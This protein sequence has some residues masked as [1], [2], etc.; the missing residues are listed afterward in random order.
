MGHWS[1]RSARARIGGAAVA[2]WLLASAGISDAPLLP[3]PNPDRAPQASVRSFTRDPDV[4]RDRLCREAANPDA[5]S[6]KVGI[7]CDIEVGRFAPPSREGPRHLTI[8]AFN[9]ARGVAAE[10]QILAFR[11]GTLPRPDVMLVSEAD[12]GCARSGYRN[13]MRDLARALE[14]D[15]VFGVEFLELPR[16]GGTGGSLDST[17]EHGNGIL[18]RFPLRRPALLR[19]GHNKSWYLPPGPWRLLGEPRLGGRATL[20]AEVDLGGRSVGLYSVHFESHPLDGA[21]RAAQA[22]EVAADAARVPGPVVVGGDFNSHAYGT[23]LRFGTRL[24]PVTRPLTEAGFVDA[25]SDV[26]PRW[27]AT[28]GPLVL[29]LILGRV[30]RGRTPDRGVFRSAGLCGAEECASLSDHRAVWATLQLD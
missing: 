2:F 11:Q 20:R 29:D 26:A 13:V 30:A 19:H 18:S 6:E 15:Y 24:D 8:M 10:A 1:G 7:T 14:M 5:A 27:R 9:L 3:P 16:T 23:D 12:R 21:Y 28:H 22:A 17:C 4:R 25:H